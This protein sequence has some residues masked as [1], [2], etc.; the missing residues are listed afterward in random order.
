MEEIPAGGYS[1]VYLVGDFSFERLPEDKILNQDARALVQ[2][3]IFGRVSQ[4]QLY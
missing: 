2:G 4:A 1:Y 3:E